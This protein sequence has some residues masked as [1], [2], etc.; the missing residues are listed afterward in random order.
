[1]CALFRTVWCGFLGVSV[2]CVWDILVWVCGFVRVNVWDSLEW[3]CGSE[4]VLCVGKFG[5]GLRE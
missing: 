1:M 2:S 3:V 5:V 4:Y